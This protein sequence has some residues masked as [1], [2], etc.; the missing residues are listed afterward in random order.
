MKEKIKKYW[1]VI[2]IILIIGGVFYWF[3]IRPSMAYSVCHYKAESQAQKLYEDRIGDKYYVSEA[4]KE[5]DKDKIKQGYYLI[6][7]YDYAYKQCLRTRGI[8]R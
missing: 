6:D 3:Q 7:D 5:K 4:E 8:N 2:I 1:L